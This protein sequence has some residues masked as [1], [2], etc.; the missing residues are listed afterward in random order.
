MKKYKRI[1]SIATIACLICSSIETCQAD[2][3]SYEQT[4][5]QFNYGVRNIPHPDKAFRGGEDAWVAQ[6]DLLI[7]ADGVGGWEDIG[8]DSGL[9]SKQLVKDI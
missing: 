4:R 2:E 7:V 6:S 5:L 3:G 9:Y 8:V 1:V